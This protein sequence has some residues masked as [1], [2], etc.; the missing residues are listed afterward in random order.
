MFSLLSVV[1]SHSYFTFSL[2]DLQQCIFLILCNRKE[3]YIAA[4][5]D[6][7]T[8]DITKSVVEES[9]EMDTSEEG[10]TDKPVQVGGQ[11]ANASIS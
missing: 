1:R 11:P 2:Q 4:F 7:P 9:N 3:Y 8:E 6:A 5:Y 10:H